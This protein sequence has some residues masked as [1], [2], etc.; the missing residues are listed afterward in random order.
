MGLGHPVIP[1][2]DSLARAALRLALV[3]LVADPWDHELL[4]QL[5]FA[6]QRRIR[7]LM[8]LP[9][10]LMPAVHRAYAAAVQASAAGSS[11]AIVAANSVCDQPSVRPVT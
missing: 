8:A 9:G 4:D 1:S 6:T 11:S 7:P 2:R 3:V 5:R 10:S